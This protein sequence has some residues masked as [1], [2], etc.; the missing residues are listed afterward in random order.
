MYDI[1]RCSVSVHK[2]KPC[3]KTNQIYP[4]NIF[5][6]NMLQN[7]TMAHESRNIWHIEKKTLFFN[8]LYLC[9]TMFLIYW[10]VGRCTAATASCS[11]NVISIRVPKC[12]VFLTVLFAS[13]LERRTLLEASHRVPL[14]PVVPVLSSVWPE[15]TLRHYPLHGGAF[16]HG[17]APN[18]QQSA[19][20]RFVEQTHNVHPVYSY[21]LAQDGIL[22][23]WL[24]N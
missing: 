17:L 9:L 13:E 4:K 8:K 2:L 6:F 24:K 22:W 1:S 11:L 21:L 5:L 18:R 12:T 23:K 15:Q 3:S 19:V 10:Q 20:N 14:K 7:Q 16:H